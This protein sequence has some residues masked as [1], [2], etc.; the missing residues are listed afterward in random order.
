MD[1]RGQHLTQTMKVLNFSTAQEK[2][3]SLLER[4]KAIVIR[5][6]E[7]YG[8]ARILLSG[9]S[10][11]KNLYSLMSG[12]DL[13]WEK[14]LIGLV[15]ERY[16]P[17]MSPYSNESMIKDCLVRNKA[18]NVQVIGMVYDLK[19]RQTNSQIVNREYQPFK[20][21]IDLIILGMGDDGHTASLF[22]GDPYSENAMISED[23]GI[24]NTL[25][26]NHPKERITC[27]L[28]MLQEAE[29]SVLLIG[30]KQKLELL[31]KAVNEYYPIT[32]FTAQDAG[33]EVY[34][35]E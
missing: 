24:F 4:F 35:S 23:L 30:G 8:D 32:P 34:Y 22:P 15:D 2:E 17:Q 25:A 5:S 7:E 14:V 21:R 33:L 12:E 31:H 29:H 1:T 16:V 6:I 19:N 11:P 27:G 26:P 10:T 28:R 13:P 20:E 18:A 9:G 3:L